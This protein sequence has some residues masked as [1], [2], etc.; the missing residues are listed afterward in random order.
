MIR[1]LVLGCVS[2]LLFLGI[3]LSGQIYGLLYRPMLAQSTDRPVVIIVAKNSSAVTFVHDLAQK[4]LIHS[5]RLFLLFIRYKG[6]ANQLKAGIY[7]IQPGET[8]LALLHHVM[9]GDVMRLPF[10][11]TDGTT[12]RNIASQIDQAPYLTQESDAWQKIAAN[13]PSPE[14]LLLADTYH[15]DAGSKSTDLLMTARQSLLHYLNDAFEKRDVNLPYKTPYDLL[16]AASII[17]KESS[18]PSDRRLI[19]S[20]IANRLHIRMPLQMDPTVIYALGSRYNGKLKHED[21]GVDSPYNTYKHYGLPPTP[22]AMV[23]KDAID[24]A[25]H[26]ATTHYLYFVASGNGCHHFSETYEQQ[27]KAISDYKVKVESCQ[28]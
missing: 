9:N 8:P 1:K 5:S 4:R 22:I 25:A 15:Y 3:I 20:V 24:A 14:G 12:Q 26:P 16:I 19:A 11:I 13:Y 21:M 2:A 10:R 23:G 7:E 6:Y 18:K 27:R 17:E 28:D